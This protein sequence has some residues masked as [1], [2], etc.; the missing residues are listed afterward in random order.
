MI[1]WFIKRIRSLQ[2]FERLVDIGIQIIAVWKFL[3]HNIW[4]IVLNRCK[5]RKKMREKQEECEIMHLFSFLFR[6]F[7]ENMQI[8]LTSAKKLYI[9]FTNNVKYGN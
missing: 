7:A 2:Q 1:S 4:L 6:I 5:N 9:I 3:A 8:I